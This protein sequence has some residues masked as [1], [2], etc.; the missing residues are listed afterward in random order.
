M[1]SVRKEDVATAADHRFIV[2]EGRDEGEIH[3]T[4][5]LAEPHICM[6]IL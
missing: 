6:Y 2:N 3:G 1:G 5:Q 4:F